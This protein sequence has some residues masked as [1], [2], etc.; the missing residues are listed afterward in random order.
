[1]QY[2]NTVCA[3]NGMCGVNEP[4]IEGR[5]SNNVLYIRMSEYSNDRSLGNH[6]FSF[7]VVGVSVLVFMLLF[8]VTSLSCR[9]RSIALVDIPKDTKT[10]ETNFTGEGKMMMMFES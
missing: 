3:D 4:P 10:I 9:K 8:V 2:C 6:D 1:M 7:L 5:G